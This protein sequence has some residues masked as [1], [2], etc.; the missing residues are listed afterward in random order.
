MRNFTLTETIKQ[1]ETVESYV[2]TLWAHLRDGSSEPDAFY[3]YCQIAKRLTGSDKDYRFPVLPL[4]MS[5]AVNSLSPGSDAYKYLSFSVGDSFLDMTWRAFW[6]SYI[7][8]DSTL[9]LYHYENGT[10]FLNRSTSSILRS[11]G[12]GYKR[13]FVGRSDSVKNKTV[14]ELNDG[15]YTEEEA[16]KIYASNIRTRAHSYRED[17]DTGLASI[18]FITDDG[19]LTDLGYRF[20]DSCE[21]TGTANSGIARE[22]FAS[23]ILQNGQLGAF[24]Y[25]IHKLS[26]QKFQANPL[27]FTTPTTSGSYAFNQNEYKAWLE[28]CFQNELYIIRKVS[29]RGGTA[30][31]PF[32]AEFAILRNLGYIKSFRIGV[33]LEINW[34]RVQESMSFSLSLT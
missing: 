7:M 33:G 3:K 5:S 14:K 32:Q 17:I 4:E 9:P 6:F 10:Y 11:D 19:K 25:Y 12:T 29:A 13:F 15:K 26:E 1:S 34:P 22:I 2:K 30:R 24:L 20:V 28:D 23:S 18:G 21:R 16:W 8:N 31:Q 27:A